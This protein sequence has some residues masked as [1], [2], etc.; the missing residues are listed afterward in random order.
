MFHRKCVKLLN[1][2]QL[3]RSEGNHDVCPRLLNCLNGNAP[4]L[5]SPVD[6]TGVFLSLRVLMAE[7]SEDVG[8]DDLESLV[9]LL[10]G[11]LPKEKVENFEVNVKRIKTERDPDGCYLSGV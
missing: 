4:A 6:Q 7:L 1:S 5:F 11:T 8:S 9:F 3:N 10:R 2:K